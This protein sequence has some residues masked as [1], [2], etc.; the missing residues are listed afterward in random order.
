[1]P[2]TEEIKLMLDIQQKSFREGVEVIFQEVNNRLRQVESLNLELKLSL[3][4]TQKE[5]EDTKRLNKVLQNEVNN[6]TKEI[7]KKSEVED[8][9]EEL[10]K[11]VDY[12]EDYSRRYN[13]R[14]DGLAEKNNETW[15]ET[16]ETVQQLLLD[17]LN[18]GTVKLERAHR[19]GPRPPPSGDARPRT[20]VV[21]FTNFNQRQLTLRSSARL[22]NTNIYINEDLCESSVQIRKEQLPALRRAKAEGKIAY[23]NHTTLVVRDRGAASDS[24][25]VGVRDRG[26][27]RVVADGGGTGQAFFRAS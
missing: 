18:I 15:E 8:K 10:K 20:V 9:L 24:S 4:F 22:K 27:A 26:E 19:V 16:Q 21:R 11:R 1:M 12:Q 13:L 3:E 5:V 7:S 25:V 23:F 6:L 2:T 14:F 17:K